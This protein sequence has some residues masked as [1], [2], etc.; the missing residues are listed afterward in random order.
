MPMP[1][2][3]GSDLKSEVKEMQIRELV[4][5]DIRDLIPYQPHPFLDVVKL[6]ANENSH[7]FPP[8]VMQAISRALRGDVFTRYPDPAG[9]KLKAKIAEVTGTKPANIVLGNGSDELIQLILQTFGG[10]G[11]RVIIPVPTFSMYKIHGQ[12]TGTIPVEV[13]RDKDFGLIIDD[14]LAE[15]NHPETRI[16]FIATPNNPTGNSVPLSQV[17]TLLEGT[18]SLVVMDEA[19]IDF[20]GESSLGLLE[21]YPNLIVLRTFSKVGLAGLRVGYLLTNREVARELLKVK[22]P[23]NVNAFSQLAALTALNHWFL[24]RQQIENIIAER[25]RI[26]TVLSGIKGVRVF[27]TDANFILFEVSGEA[28]KVHQELL[29]RGVLVR[30]RPGITHGLPNCLRVTVGTRQENEFFLA[31]IKDI[32]VV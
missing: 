10:P 3:C 6:D 22:Q 4:R 1:M 18:K 15:M 24:F 14:M 16:T 29:D 23:Y 32:L 21:E 20:G 5:E 13:P 17:R 28:P 2:Q 25:A 9:E 31:K 19:Y 7:A 30:N 27:P 12:I 11:K 26:N 8:E